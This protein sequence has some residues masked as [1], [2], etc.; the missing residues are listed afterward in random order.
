MLRSPSFRLPAQECPDLACDFVGN[1][2]RGQM[3]GLRD[4]RHPGGRNIWDKGPLKRIDLFH[5]VVFTGQDEGGDADIVLTHC[6][7]SGS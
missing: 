2:Q 4:D 6:L 1:L 7:L 3:A 5:L